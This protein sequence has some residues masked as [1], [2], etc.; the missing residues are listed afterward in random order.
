MDGG[1]GAGEYCL[2]SVLASLAIASPRPRPRTE[3]AQLAHNGTELERVREQL[4]LGPLGQPLVLYT[5]VKNGEGLTFTF[6]QA[7]G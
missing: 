4:P 7:L 3:L 6:V 1:D 2:T 5:A